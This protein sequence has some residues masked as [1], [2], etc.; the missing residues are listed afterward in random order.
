MK[1]SLLL[2][3]AIPLGLIVVIAFTA[4]AQG[5]IEPW[6]ALVFEAMVGTLAFMWIVN[7]F[8]KRRLTL[9]IP[10]F[11][12][13]LLAF[14]ALG[15]AQS[16]AWYDAAGNRQ[17]LSL[18]VE[19]TRG[20]VF[21]LCC[22]LACCL[23][24][25]NYLAGEDRMR[26]TAAFLSIYGMTLGLAAVVLHFAGV[27]YSYW[28]W[29]LLAE[30][31]FGPFLNRDHFAAYMEL[32]IGVPVGMILTR[33][34]RGE[35]TLLYGVA[36]VIMGTAAIF[37]LSRGGMISLFAQMLFIAA[38]GGGRA[39]QTRRESVARVTVA[40]ISFN[41]SRRAAAIAVVG[42]ILLAIGA[43]VLWIGVE[44]VINRI[45]TGNP[46]NADRR[47]A[48]TFHNV[49][50]AIW[51]DSWRIVREHPIGGAGLGA[52]ETA[53]SLYA[54]NR[55]N[56]SRVGQAHNDYL[57]VLTDAGLI[58]GALALWFLVSL[59]SAM[60]RSLFASD[61]L[62][63]G[64]ALG[65]CAGIFGSLIHSIFDFSL[66][67]PSHAILFLSLSALVA[68]IGASARKPQ[69]QAAV[70]KNIVADFSEAHL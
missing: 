54:W 12:W 58:G 19:A 36:A 68:H 25:A 53:Y 5:V 24:A 32:L 31:T 66:H 63:A 38:A 62:S 20:S 67:L 23:L 1:K 21:M 70:S 41:L 42:A 46:E 50:G 14:L 57:Q 45:A 64:I 60:M 55:G 7:V 48:Q 33:N 3:K 16:V 10:S 35:K 18:D 22:L 2:D 40:K 51:Q 30:G 44:P 17:S 52:F 65:A 27:Q 69:P 11:A 13:P 6:S 8:L 15:L 56:E 49:R 47:Q 9:M 43:G 29:P 34:V 4:L 39:K 59:I 61:S 28:P 26:M 37:T